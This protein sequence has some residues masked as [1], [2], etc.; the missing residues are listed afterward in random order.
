MSRSKKRSCVPI[1]S[2]QQPEE[3]PCV[4]ESAYLYLGQLCPKVTAPNRHP[5][6]SAR[7]AV[8]TASWK[9]RRQCQYGVCCEI[10]IAFRS[11]GFAAS[12]E[13]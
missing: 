4:P 5:R 3:D 8:L 13:F 1:R 2:V 6:I 10:W 9:S 11:S 12:T 7:P